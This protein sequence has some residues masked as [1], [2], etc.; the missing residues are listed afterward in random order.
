MERHAP[1][2]EPSLNTWPTV[3]REKREQELSANSETGIERE[4]KGH[5]MHRKPGT[6]SRVAQGGRIINQQ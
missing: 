6:E 5:V 3:K 4:Q 2:Y 1:V